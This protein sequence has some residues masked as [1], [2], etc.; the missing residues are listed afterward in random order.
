MESVKNEQKFDEFENIEKGRL[1]LIILLDQ[2]SRTIYNDHRQYETDHIATALTLNYLKF[3]DK[4]EYSVLEKTFLVVV[5][6]H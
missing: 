4:N 1:A 3:G 6:E 2:V 5:L